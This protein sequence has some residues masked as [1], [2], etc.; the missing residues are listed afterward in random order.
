VSSVRRAWRWD[1]IALLALLVAGCARTGQGEASAL[2]GTGTSSVPYETGATTVTIHVRMELD[3]GRATVAVVSPSGVTM[4][5]Q[6]YVGS[7][8]APVVLDRTGAWSDGAGRWLVVLTTTD[9]Q[10]RLVTEF[11]DG[12]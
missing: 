4:W 10:G 9:A 7:T 5:Q 11:R 3:S 6:Q 1:T 12:A 8:A 2:M